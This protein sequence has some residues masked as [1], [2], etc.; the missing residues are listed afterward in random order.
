MRFFICLIFILVSFQGKAQFDWSFSFDTIHV[1][2]WPGIHS[3]AYGIYEQKLYVFGGRRD[4]LHPKESG[5]ERT[6]ANDSIFIIDLLNLK[7]TSVALDIEDVLLYDALTTSGMQFIQKNQ[8]LYL[9]GGYGESILGGYKT[10]PTLTEIKLN[11]LAIA[12]DKQAD[13]SKSIRYIVDSTFTVAGGQMDYLEDIFFLV[14]GHKFEGKYKSSDNKQL[15]TYTD[16]A[17]LFKIISTPDTFYTQKQA[18]ILDEFNFH[19][20][21]YNL[22]KINMADGGE[23]LLIHSGVFMINEAR[24]FLNMALLDS[25][26]Y[27]DVDN[28]LHKYANYHCAKTLLMDSLNNTFHI[29]FYGGMSEF[30]IDSFAQEIRDPFVPFVSSVSRISRMPTDQFIEQLHAEQLPGFF[31]SSAEFIVHPTFT[32]DGEKI[33]DISTLPKDTNMIGWILGG[34]WN[35]SLE[36]NPWQKDKA[37][38]T[39]SNPYFIPVFII[40]NKTGTK[41]KESNNVYTKLNITCWPNPCE[42]HLTITLEKDVTS[43]CYWIQNSIGELVIYNELKEF[44]NEFQIPIRHL[45]SGSYK[46]LLSTDKK[47]LTTHNFIKK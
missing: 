35:P 19:R 25:L 10:F 30:Y 34:I 39:R 36:R 20:R 2:G 38:L 3:F 42:D 4:G 43:I 18:E 44:K 45:I 8:S 14:G 17:I 41:T 46:L 13:I 6:Q 11:E 7:V 37:H 26:G 9:I 1:P 28:F 40:K 47:E 5:F 21:D 32:K 22:N 29:I 12:I 33:I 23:K 27:K 16:K 31:G 24:P 15:Q